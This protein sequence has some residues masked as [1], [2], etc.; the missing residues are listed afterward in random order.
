M[1]RPDVE[2]K[3]Q[4]SAMPVLFGVESGS[5]VFLSSSLGGPGGMEGGGRFSSSPTS[6]GVTIRCWR[7][8]LILARVLPPIA[9][10]FRKGYIDRGVIVGVSGMDIFPCSALSE[11]RLCRA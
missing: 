10:N 8:T 7:L 5:P 3:G 1:I 4:M 9:M 6:L 2:K 11:G